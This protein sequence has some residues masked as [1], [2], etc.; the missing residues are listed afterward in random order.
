MSP[1][2]AIILLDFI[3]DIEAPRGYDTIYGNN[4]HRLKTPV[5]KLTVD[6]VI[7][8][9]RNWSRRYGSSATGRYQFMRATLQ[10]LKRELN[11]TGNERMTPAFQDKL[12]YHLLK[13]RGYTTFVVG[14]LTVRQF[15]KRLA[16]EWASLPVLDATQGAHRPLKRGQS[17]YAGD[18]LNKSL[19][20]P[21]RVEAILAKVLSMKK[22]PTVTR[23]GKRTPDRSKRVKMPAPK[24]RY[25]F[26]IIADFFRAI[27][28]RRS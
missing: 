17:Y 18:K 6:Q 14:G 20:R 5:T 19:V 11:L 24:K 23:H 1:K 15:G 16:Q 28:R 26:D 8:N 2:S 22:S 25:L 13:R 21:D 27:F 12:G 4:Q 9:Q 7:A 3:G 10:G